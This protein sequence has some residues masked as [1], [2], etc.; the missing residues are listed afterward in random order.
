M[1]SVAYPVI[2]ANYRQSPT[3]KKKV[4]T[5]HNSRNKQSP[6]PHVDS[7]PPKVQTH[8]HF[9]VSRIQ[10]DQKRIAS[11]ERENKKLLEKLAEIY[12]GKGIVD[13]WNEYRQKSSNREKQNR[14]IVKITLENQRILK[15]LGNLEA[16]YDHRKYEIDWQNSR[17]YIRNTSRYLISSRNG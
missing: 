15:K 10:E 9:K 8:H 5:D 6:A 11:I 13:C 16:T 2:V 17:C 12:R 1:G 4:D 3:R 14:E 7:K